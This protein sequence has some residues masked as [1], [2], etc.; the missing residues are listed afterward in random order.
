MSANAL[1]IR[2]LKKSFANFT[3]GPRRPAA[4]LFSA[5]GSAAPR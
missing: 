2:G 4:G 1:E 3:L 5:S